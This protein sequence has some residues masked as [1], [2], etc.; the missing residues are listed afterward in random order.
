MMGEEKF[1]QSE[2]IQKPKRGYHLVSD[3]TRQKLITMVS[4]ERPQ[5]YLER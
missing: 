4:M 3:E 5:I 1:T 2:A